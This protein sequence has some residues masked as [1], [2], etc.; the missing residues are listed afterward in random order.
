MKIALALA[1]GGIRG[2]A[3]IGVIKAL[4]EEGFE[5]SAISGTSSGSII[6][7]LFS[8]GYTA[9]EMIKLFRYF[10]KRIV[11]ISPKHIYSNIRE[12]KGFT[13]GGLTSSKA[14]EDIVNEAGKFKGIKNIK[15]IKLPIAIP[16]TDLIQDR[17][18]IFTNCEK[19]E[20]NEYISDIEIG[21]AVR[22]SST[23]PCFYAPFE[24]KDYQ[25]VDGGLFENV[26][27]KQAKKLNND[28]I[29]AVKFKYETPKKQKSMYNILMHSLDLMTERI[30]NKTLEP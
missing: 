15:D 6:A 14:L 8:M 25:F 2:A 11:G 22:A 23:F 10:S 1:G 19:M 21:K 28:K 18:I 5:I 16:A 29:I 17:E 12:V 7:A 20:G 9:D 3:H 4:G 13:I 30:N 24:Y 27:I 26:P